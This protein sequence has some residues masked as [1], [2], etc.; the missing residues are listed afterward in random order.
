MAMYV[1]VTTTDTQERNKQMKRISANVRTWR[2]AYD[3]YVRDLLR[4]FSWDTAYP[5]YTSGSRF[6]DFKILFYYVF[7]FNLIFAK[8]FVTDL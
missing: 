6:Q 4:D 1:V 2:T 7:N 5:T 3:K 8:A